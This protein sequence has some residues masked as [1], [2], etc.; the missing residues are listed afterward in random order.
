MTNKKPA[1]THD[2]LVKKIK[3]KGW[4]FVASEDSQNIPDGTLEDLVKTAH[5]RHKSGQHPG[6]IKEIETEAELDLIQLEKLWQ[7]LGLPN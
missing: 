2:E 7:Y 4:K 5:K 3:S 6:L 1:P